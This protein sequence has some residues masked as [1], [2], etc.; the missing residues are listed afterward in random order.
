MVNRKNFRI[1]EPGAEPDLSSQD[2]EVAPDHGEL[3]RK[4]VTRTPVG[5][6]QVSPSPEESGHASDRESPVP[7]RRQDQT[8]SLAIVDKSALFRTGLMSILAGS[9][10]RVSASCG[11]INELTKRI[12]LE[13][14]T[15][16]V[17]TLDREA[18]IILGQAAGLIEQGIHVLVL[19]EEFRPEEV[20]A[21]IETGVDGYLLK[22]EID[23]DALV[24][25]LELV[26]LRGVVLPH[27][28]GK[29]LKGSL[30]P[31][32]MFRGKTPDALPTVSP[33]AGG[34]DQNSTGGAPADELARLSNRERMILVH[35][36]QGASNKQIAR[37]LSISEA[38]VKVYVKSLL[39]K[40]RVDNRTQA[41]I[42]GV[43]NLNRNSLG[44]YVV[45]CSI[46]ANLAWVLH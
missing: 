3:D 11:N 28:F 23:P 16:A 34:Q 25:S 10:F 45:A 1:A 18:D 9:R 46:I 26:C 43:G 21:A 32:I 41:A 40:I 36:T 29:L 33:V 30:S 2:K 4:P 5:A 17:V 31:D 20:F 19:S 6:D 39:R 8:V 37:E 15:V 44:I 35:L 7:L 14:P 24:T 22:N 13:K 38:T 12:P 42:W 27:G